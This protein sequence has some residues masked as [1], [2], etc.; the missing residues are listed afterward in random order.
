[1]RKRKQACLKLVKSPISDNTEY[2]PVVL[3]YQCLAPLNS[4]FIY[5][6]QD[7][8]VSYSFY[9]ISICSYIWARYLFDLIEC[10]VQISWILCTIVL[11][12]VYE[13]LRD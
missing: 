12:S 13:E 1:M 9:G 5:G 7:H 6:A 10:Y 2:Q 8:F 3:Q 4:L 11:D